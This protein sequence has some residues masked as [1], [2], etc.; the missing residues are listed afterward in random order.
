MS[1]TPGCINLIISFYCSI[2]NEGRSIEMDPLTAFG[3]FRHHLFMIHLSIFVQIRIRPRQDLAPK[4]VD[5]VLKL[6]KAKECKTC[7]FYRH[8]PAPENFGKDGFF[9]PPYALLQ[10]SLADMDENPP[11]GEAA[12]WVNFSPPI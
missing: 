6:S 11:F 2:H 1:L 8:E 10:G 12:S 3:K 5:L 7:R 9:G 4:I